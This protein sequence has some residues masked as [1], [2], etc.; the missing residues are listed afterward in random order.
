[1]ADG[2]RQAIYRFASSRHAPARN[3]AIDAEC[4]V[5]QLRHQVRHGQLNHMGMA[6]V[7]VREIA[8]TPAACSFLA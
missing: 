2:N 7:I 8:A 3:P 6:P 4:F 1:M 5:N